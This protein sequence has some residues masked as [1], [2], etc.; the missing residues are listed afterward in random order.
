MLVFFIHSHSAPFRLSSICSFSTQLVI[1]AW[2]SIYINT[3]TP[4]NFCNRLYQSVNYYISIYG[5]Q[6]K[7]R[8]SAQCNYIGINN[9]FSLEKQ[10]RMCVFFSVPWFR[11]ICMRRAYFHIKIIS[12]WMILSI[13]IQICLVFFSFTS[14]VHLS[15]V[16]LLPPH[17]NQ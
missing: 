10:S 15:S 8:T 1:T 13:T 9:N 16:A 7:K 12:L 11:C 2:L 6:K 5:G 17:A 4:D 3:Y 14:F